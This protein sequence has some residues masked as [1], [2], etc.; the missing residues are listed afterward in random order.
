MC[1]VTVVIPALNEAAR[2][3]DTILTTMER[4]RDARV[5]VVDGGSTDATGVIAAAAGADALTGTRGRGSQC[6][7]GALAATSEWLLFLHDDTT[8]PSNAD[9]VIARFI[10]Q[11]NSRVATFRL[12]FDEPGRFLRT[13]ARSRASTAYS[14]VSATRVF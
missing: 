7:A 4:V 1:P 5:I 2:I 10:A 9:E 8:L 6:H 11:T 12:R 3:R 14:L 13:A